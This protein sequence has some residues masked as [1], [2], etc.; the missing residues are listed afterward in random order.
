MPFAMNDAIAIVNAEHSVSVLYRGIVTRGILN[1][2][3]TDNADTSHMAREVAHRTLIVAKGS[4][5]VPVRDD[6]ITID[7][8][9]YFIRVREPDV[10]NVD[11]A[12]EYWTVA[13]A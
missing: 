1:E 8:N 3:I 6:P 5:G 2:S 10:G 9:A 4:I 11:D 7:K 13:K 12:H